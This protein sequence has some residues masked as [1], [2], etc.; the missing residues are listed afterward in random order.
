MKGML[1]YPLKEALSRAPAGSGKYLGKICTVNSEHC[2]VER[3]AISYDYGKRV[4]RMPTV[5]G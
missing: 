5:W 2:G 3:Y 4:R 1:D